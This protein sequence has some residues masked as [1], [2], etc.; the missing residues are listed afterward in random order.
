MP[1]L[2]HISM[3]ENNDEMTVSFVTEKNPN[4]KPFVEYKKDGED[5][6]VTITDAFASTYSASELCNAPANE[7]TSNGLQF[8]DPGLLLTFVVTI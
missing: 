8:R 2:V 7:T 3:T 4:L 6:S 1:R 5:K